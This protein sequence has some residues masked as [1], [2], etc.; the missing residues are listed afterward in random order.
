MRQDSETVLELGV[1]EFSFADPASFRVDPRSED[2]TAANSSARNAIPA[3]TVGVF[4]GFGES[5]IPLV[6]FPESSSVEPIPARSIVPLTV[7]QIGC[8]VALVFE[9]GNLAMPI[10]LGCL[11][12]S[13]LVQK[14]QPLEVELDG[15]KLTLSAEREIVLRC[16]KSSI[17][18]TR[19]GKVLIC[20]EYVLSRSSGLNRINGAS[21]QIN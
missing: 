1:N 19:S 20:G 17:T 11:Q 4:R 16:G 3:V 10:V 15:G 21:V 18:L 6:E 12:A 7:H 8:E 5:G 2:S 14:K 13:T 9:R